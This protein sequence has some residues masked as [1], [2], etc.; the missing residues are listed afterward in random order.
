M[1]E[2]FARPESGEGARGDAGDNVVNDVS[3]VTDSAQV[4][5]EPP[6]WRKWLPQRR[7]DA[8]LITD[9]RLGPAQDRRRREREYMVLQGLRVPSL[10]FGGIFLVMHWWLAAVLVL[11]V[12]LPL[13]WIAVMLGNSKGQAREERER[14]VYRPGLA[15]Q[16][17]E[18]L[19]QA[20]QIE[21]QPQRPALGFDPTTV[22]D[23]D[24]TNN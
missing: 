5:P 16:Y 22:I 12:T 4:Q 20:A 1:D 21:N 15:R 19:R 23:H 10:V 17:N 3:D 8:A 9:A 24:D 11:A 14:M 13:P 18:Q 2:G 7:G 6:R